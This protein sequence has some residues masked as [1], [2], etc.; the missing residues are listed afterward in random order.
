MRILHSADW[1][2]D[3]PFEALPAEKAR[4]MRAEAR[5]IP[6]RIADLAS[7]LGADVVLLCGDLFDTQQPGAAS[8]EAVAA[9]LRRIDCPVFIA[10]GNHDWYRASGGLWRS[11]ELPDNVY[12][13]TGGFE[14]F[15]LPCADVYGAAFTEPHCAGGLAGFRAERR[16]KPAVM[17][18]HGT[19]DAAGDYRPISERDIAATGLDYLALGHTHRPSGLRRAGEVCYAWPGCAMGRGFDECGA[20]GAYFAEITEDGCELSF[21]ELTRRRYEII[22]AETRGDAAAALREAVAS[23]REGDIC[24]FVL[25]GESEQRV[26]QS[27]LDALA[28]ERGLFAAFLRDETAPPRV[29]CS[30]D[31]LR[32]N[33]LRIARERLDAAETEAERLALSRAIRWGEAALCG[34]DAPWE[35]S[36]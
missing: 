29:E 2:L 9:G 15:E 21:Y 8:R 30:A 6:G 11:M 28:D 36:G 35:V 14:R 32:G 33:F 19:L 20:R 7:E 23:A 31:S 26:P 4:A 25:R 1:H 17:A 12:I 13:F 10:P 5:E 24:R 3:S 27:L 34:D 18:L 16:G 22:E